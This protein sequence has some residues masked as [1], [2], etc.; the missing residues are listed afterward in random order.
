M[1]DSNKVVQL[2]RSTLLRDNVACLTSQVAQLLTSRATNL[3]DRS[4][5]YSRQL[6]SRATKRS[7]KVAQLCCVSDI[8]P[9]LKGSY[10]RYIEQ[11]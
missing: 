1:S 5:P 9:S 8:G 6:L 11:R 3:L 4:H 2:S 10:M 7:E